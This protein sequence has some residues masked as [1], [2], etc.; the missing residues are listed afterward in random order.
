[1]TC[2]LAR[3]LVDLVSGHFCLI[4]CPERN[5]PNGMSGTLIFRGVVPKGSGCFGQR[6]SNAAGL[7]GVIGDE[8]GPWNSRSGCS[9]QSGLPGPPLSEE[10]ARQSQIHSTLRLHT[11]PPWFLSSFFFSY[12][13]LAF[14]LSQHHTVHFIA[15]GIACGE[16][17][18]DEAI[19]GLAA[20]R[21][22]ASAGSGWVAAMDLAQLSRVRRSALS[23]TT[24][25]SA[26]RTSPERR[27]WLQ[28]GTGWGNKVVGL[29]ERNYGE[30]ITARDPTILFRPPDD[31][32][33]RSGLPVATDVGVFGCSRHAP[34][35]HARGGRSWVQLCLVPAT[36][37]QLAPLAG[38][39]CGLPGSLIIQ[40]R[41]A[42]MSL[43]A[44]C[45]LRR[46][47]TLP[48]FLGELS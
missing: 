25:E 11:T 8:R 40:S 13:G 14:R 12:F 29:S 42:F 46:T 24:L 38:L 22:M 2:V 20:M 30:G 3:L 33:F 1:M 43:T 27:S 6:S 31:S 16:V 44:C 39:G 32:R 15:S 5:L 26:R 7:S 10:G 18:G 47:V 45:A 19:P 37:H 4:R 9:K 36:S 35:Y 48:P 21:A 17:T 34:R 41:L 23:S 28:L